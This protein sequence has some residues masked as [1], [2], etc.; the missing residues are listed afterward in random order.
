MRMFRVWLQ[1]EQVND[2]DESDSEVR[3]ALPEQCGRC[4]S[5]LGRDVAG[6][7][8]DNIGFVTFIIAGPIPDANALCAVGNRGINVEVLQMLL[9]VRDNDVDV[10]FGSQAMIGYG[11]QTV[12]IR[13]E[14]DACDCGAFVEYY[15]EKTRILVCEA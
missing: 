3:E 12:G 10:V 11:Q 5:F 1:L 14:I 7:G 8:K 6:C 2:I 9:F 15:I 4:Q 13:W